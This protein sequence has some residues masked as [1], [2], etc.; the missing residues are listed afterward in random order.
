MPK[1]KR[2]RA[3]KSSSSDHVAESAP[4]SREDIPAADIAMQL[5]SPEER[6]AF[7]LP[8]L[9][10]LVARLRLALDRETNPARCLRLYD[11][12]LQELEAARDKGARLYTMQSS[13]GELVNPEDVEMYAARLVD[14]IAK[15]SL[16]RE[17]LRL[18]HEA[19]SPLIPPPDAEPL[20]RSSVPSASSFA[21]ASPAK[22]YPEVLTASEIWEYLRLTED[23]FYQTWERLGIPVFREG[24]QLRCRKTKL[25]AWIE[26]RE[27]EAQAKP[28]N[29]GRGRSPNK[30]PAGNPP[31]SIT[32]TRE[33]VV[34]EPKPEASPAQDNAYSLSGLDEAINALAGMLVKRRW[35]DP[36]SGPRLGEW[37][38][39]PKDFP[40]PP[41]NWLA[42]TKTLYSL[43]VCLCH[44]NI[45][46][47]EPGSKKKGAAAPQYEP[48]ISRAFHVKG[49]RLK[50]GI[51]RT[52]M[53]HEI[54]VKHFRKV[55]TSYAIEKHGI[56]RR[57]DGFLDNIDLYYLHHEK[58]DF[59]TA[60][61][62]LE[63]EMPMVVGKSQVG[64]FSVLDDKVL[65]LLLN[66][67]TD[68]PALLEIEP[69]L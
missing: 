18:D 59:S 35:L 58:K 39:N 57:T 53:K 55:L 20:V 67:I 10:A 60:A 7:E 69:T 66:L 22:V 61:R 11:L 42:G 12:A 14:L 9:G 13:A 33:E 15:L 56:D 37:M 19:S 32:T 5:T 27:K 45:L 41:L 68:Y 38:A 30:K 2:R 65:M 23:R 31:T 44:A 51:N 50:E 3:T 17:R 26:K 1:P 63:Q 24:S 25:D 34:S 64:V 52:V 40:G 47:L 6:A 48:A 8:D 4:R 43:V 21:P 54:A 49:Q 29:S 28:I 36:E 46:V 62:Q 16:E